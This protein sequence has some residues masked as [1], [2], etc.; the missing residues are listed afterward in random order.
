[1][2]SKVKISGPVFAKCMRSR[3]GKHSVLLLGD[4]HFS[5]AG[6]C[7]K[8]SETEQP[9]DKHDDASG[10]RDLV[11]TFLRSGDA[12]D[13]ADVF[14]E[15]GI[16][17]MP[18]TLSRMMHKLTGEVLGPTE[19]GPL[20]ELIRHFA[21]RGCLE[22]GRAECRKRYPHGRVHFVDR[23][24]DA[25]SLLYE[26]LPNVGM[27]L[28]AAVHE[29]SLSQA[30]AQARKLAKAFDKYPTVQSLTKLLR[31]RLST[32][33]NKS[34]KQVEAIADKATQKKV[35]DWLHEGEKELVDLYGSVY[36]EA[37]R[38]LDAALK[39]NGGT[40]RALMLW[41]LAYPTK[42][43]S[44]VLFVTIFEMDVYTM[45]RLLREFKDGTRAQRSMVYAGDAHIKNYEGLLAKLGW[46]DC[47]KVS[48]HSMRCFS[49]TLPKAL[50]AN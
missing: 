21:D 39:D 38:D 18:G 2:P 16:R 12:V 40:P 44:M 7:D 34:T 37:K 13:Y 47:G 24:Q 29:G 42:L 45:G 43:V 15:A 22:Y 46:K 27:G 5:W 3:D 1:M 23:R 26:L 14:V 11:D 32:S 30:R 10:V 48:Y 35:W 41:V 4:A 9:G 50:Q 31:S 49:V 19:S 17:E 8:S 20:T 36:K 28:A 6:T 25:K 33:A